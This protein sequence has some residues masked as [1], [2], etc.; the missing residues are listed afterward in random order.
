MPLIQKHVEVGTTIHTDCWRA[1]DCLNEHGY[2]RK[3]VNHSDPDNPFIAED[4]TLTLLRIE[5]HW[6]AVK[7]FFMKD[8]YNNPESFADVI[9]EYLW[10]RNVYKYKKDPFLEML[11]AIKH[12]NKI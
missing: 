12:V 6:R 8:N 3:K 4:D 11:K 1:Y 7:R 10:R 2:I 9:T 5:S